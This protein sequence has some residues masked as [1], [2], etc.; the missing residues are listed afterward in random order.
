[1]S[2]ACGCC[3]RG[4]WHSTMQ[5][6]DGGCLGMGGDAGSHGTGRQGP[7]GW[8]WQAGQG[9]P[10]GV[11]THTVAGGGSQLLS[12]PLR[13]SCGPQGQAAL[14]RHIPTA[15]DAK[16]K[17]SPPHW[18]PK[19]PPALHTQAT[20]LAATLHPHPP[21]LPRCWSH[22]I[23]CLWGLHFAP[24]RGPAARASRAC[25]VPSEDPQ[26]TRSTWPVTRLLLKC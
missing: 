1:M 19:R 22:P 17:A 6:Q 5:R 7:W 2:D 14:T 9:S 16:P 3:A 18:S 11:L 26:W 21:H 23:L 20:T 10:L 12:R 4:H 15:A 24:D 25:R 8:R 13:P